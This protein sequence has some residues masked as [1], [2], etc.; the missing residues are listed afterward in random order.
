MAVV[1]RIIIDESDVG[2][3]PVVDRQFNQVAVVGHFNMGPV[4]KPVRVQSLAEAKEIFGTV[5][6]AG[7]TGMQSLHG[8]YAQNARADVWV[9]RILPTSVAPVVATKS[10]NDSA[11]PVL[12]ADGIGHG[13]GY[14]D[15]KVAISAAGDADADHF[16]A[17]VT[18]IP[19]GRT[20]VW[21]NLD[22]TAGNN[23]LAAAGGPNE[24]GAGSELVK[25]VKLA[26]GRP[27]DAAAANLTTGTNGTPQASDY[28]GTQ[29]ASGNRTGVYVLNE[30]PEV[31]YIVLAQQT[32]ATAHDGLETYVGSR[33]IEDGL[34]TGIIATA[35]NTAPGSA[36]VGTVDSDRMLA[37]YPFWTSSVAQV[38]EKNTYL[39]IDGHVAGLLSTL[40]EH[41]SPSNKEIKGLTTPRYKV[42]FG[43]VGTLVAA[44]I[45]AV[46]AVPNRGVRMR[47]GLT[48]SKDAA[49]EQFSLRNQYDRLEKLYYDALAWVVSENNTPGLRQQV[50]DVMDAINRR[51]VE[52]EAIAGFRDTVCD[53]TNNTPSS[54]A[55]G[56]LI[57][58]AR[59]RFAYPADEVTI[60]IS[61]DVA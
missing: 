28:V 39:A 4:N 13:T 10:F 58:Q 14:N 16:K 18:H 19:T 36:T 37:V 61:R 55:A 40:Q 2:P 17:T 38:E 3:R 1:P 23:N 8:V 26:D 47:S 22:I 20:E 48:T 34:V 32:S 43:Q 53:E 50:A 29:D 31:R 27:D 51:E 59:V 25:F 12:R 42:T 54:I 11:T 6:E 5:Y 9:V 57:A 30:V 15:V 41:Q 7:M 24:A 33:T 21:D 49:W 45:N 46:T 56:K 44:R 35:D 52:R 60:A